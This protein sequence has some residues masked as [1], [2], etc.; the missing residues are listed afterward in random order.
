MTTINCPTCS[1]EMPGFALSCPKCGRPTGI[2]LG[3][4]QPVSAP[5]KLGI[6]L[7]PLIFSWFTL[8]KEYTLKTKVISFS[9]LVFSLA[10]IGA[11]GF[12]N[13]SSKNGEAGSIVDAAP[14]NIMQVKIRDIL[15]LY[16]N[17]EAEADI[18]YKGNWIEVTGLVD[19]IKKDQLGNTYM[20]IGTGQKIEIPKIQAFFD[21]AND[22]L[23]NINKR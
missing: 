12:K 20:T 15:S 7:V 23:A 2:G 21:D 14:I 18:E 1:T 19:N 10:I 4:F 13:I 22:Q 9:W 8:G 5:L 16:K 17:N 3:L 11:L 6:F